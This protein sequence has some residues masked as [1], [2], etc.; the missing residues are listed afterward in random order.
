M[1]LLLTYVPHYATMSQ[2][3][4]KSKA[5]HEIQGVAG[6]GQIEQCNSIKYI[7]NSYPQHGSQFFIHLK[8]PSIF[9]DRIYQ[10]KNFN[11]N[12]KGYLLGSP[13]L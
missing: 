5:D 3:N 8:R 1:L 10:L 12:L 9:V 4:P 7:K 6:L 2:K 13:R 11:M